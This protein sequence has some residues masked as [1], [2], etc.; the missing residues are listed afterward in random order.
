MLKKTKG[1]TWE[2]IYG[3][4][5]A[6]RKREGIQ[7]KKE[8]G[9]LKKTTKGKTWEEIYGVEEAKRK[10]ENLKI[11][12]PSKYLSSEV[13]QEKSKKISKS[14]K[15]RIGEK[16]PF[17]GKHH[18]KE[19]KEQWS[20]ERKLP[21][22]GIKSRITAAKKHQQFIEE[23]TIEV[24]CKNCNKV[25]KKIKSD[26]RI[27]CNKQ[28]RDEWRRTTNHFNKDK[29]NGW[30]QKIID[31]KIDSLEYVGNH[32]FWITL[33][34]N[35]ENKAIF[36]NPDFIIRPHRKNKKVIEVW[37]NYWH[38]NHDKEKLRQMYNKSN[39]E[40]LFLDNF[41]IK[42]KGQYL[43]NKIEEFINAA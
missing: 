5:G 14:A 42:Q 39:I 31:L 10:R 26:E 32:S 34:D 27:M 6:K 18:S 19:K 2:E 8:L 24:L 29:P 1:K 3:I 13:K 35:E 11:N 28:C 22:F 15:T 16:N 43:K 21:E 25:F 4:E 36:K 17:F 40:V 12:N 33:F 41:D 20:N 38:R 23:N 7:K 37:G 30:E 9:L